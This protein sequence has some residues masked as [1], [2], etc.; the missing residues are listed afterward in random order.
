MGA[1][2]ALIKVRVPLIVCKSHGEICLII[3][4]LC[5][6]NLRVLQFT[7]RHR[8]NH[9]RQGWLAGD[10]GRDARADEARDAHESAQAFS[11]STARGNHAWSTEAF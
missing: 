3:P 1:T 10:E 4:S 2:T 5:A 8:G 9:F 6:L 11:R 7:W